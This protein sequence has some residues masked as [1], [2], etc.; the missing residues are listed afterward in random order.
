MILMESPT[1]NTT[2]AQIEVKWNLPPVG[3]LKLNIDES[4]S[5]NPNSKEIGGAFRD[6]TGQ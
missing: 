1:E 2:N 4:T 3:T 5:G 6:H